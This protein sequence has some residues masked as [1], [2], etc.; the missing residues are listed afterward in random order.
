MDWYVYTIFFCSVAWEIMESELTYEDGDTGIGQG[1]F[2][3]V[4]VASY[5]GMQV[6][7]KTIQEKK[8]CQL[9]TEGFLQEAAIIT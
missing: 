8:A 4:H 2:G 7:V 3:E 1:E 5:R 9:A 6:A